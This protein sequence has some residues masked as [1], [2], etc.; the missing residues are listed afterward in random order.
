LTNV[1]RFFGTRSPLRRQYAVAAGIFL[2]LVLGIIFLFGHLIAGSLSRRYLEDVLAGGRAEAQRIAAELG[3]AEVKELDVVE[4]RRE[5]LTRTLEGDPE[6]RIWQSIEVTD[7]EGKVVYSSRREST[8][9]IPEALANDL[10]FQGMLSDEGVVETENPY[11]ISVPLG[12]VGSVVLNV[13][14]AEVAERVSDLRGDL[15]AQ[16][17]GIAVLTL[18]T[19]LFA[20]AFVWFLIQRTRRLEAQRFEAE[21]MAALG[22]LAAN[23]AHEIRNPLN[24]INLNLELLDEDLPD[25]GQS[26]RESLASTRAEVGR[27][28]KLVS[29]FLT[30]ARPH[31]PELGSVRVDAMLTEVGEFLTAEAHSLGVHLRV[32]PG[33]PNVSVAGDEAQVRQVLLNLVLNAVQAVHALPADRRVVELDADEGSNSVAMVVR[34]RGDGIPS[35][36]MARVRKAF[37]TRRRGGSGL[38]LAIA[39][40]FIDAQGGHIDLVNHEPHGF[41][42]RV[43]LPIDHEAVKI[44][45]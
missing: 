39:E 33:L 26:A 25:D 36:E 12:E 6:R 13:D 18:A 11:R 31:E 4:T 5:V 2:V 8:E 9:E 45:G 34:D 23:L 10:Q 43:V 1:G 16:T 15:L 42:A 3:G 35:E 19:L 30:Y 32:L 29:D 38:G 27:L 37:Y 20:F 24:S 44:S 22:A 7:S 21:E 28:A 14:R 40:R 41:E 17:I